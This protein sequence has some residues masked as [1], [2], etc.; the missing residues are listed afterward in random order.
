MQT[1]PPL[2]NAPF[3]GTPQASR[4][5]GVLCM[6]GGI[7]TTQK[8]PVCGGA[9]RDNGRWG[10]TC[11]AH[12]EQEAAKLI[13]KFG[14]VWKRFRSYEAA[15]RFL[16]GLR[17]KVDEGSF[18]SRDYRK[19]NP[20]GFSTLA[21][22][23]L[24]KKKADIRPRVWR[25]Y[26]NYMSKAVGF[27]GGRNIKEIGYAD[28]E[29]FL[30]AQRGLSPKTRA[31]VLS[32][33]HHFWVWLRKRRVITPAQFPEFPEVK[34]ELGYRRT[35]DKETQL[36]ILEEVRRLSWDI[37]PRV[38]IGIRFLCTYISIRPA[39]MAALKEG[40]ID[41]GNG[42]LLIP[43]PKEKTLKRVPLTP[44]DIELLRALPRG[45]PELPFF[46]HIR[47]YKGSRPGQPFG[48]KHFYNWWKRACRNLGVEGVDLYGGTRHSSALAL[49]AEGYSPE[50]I[51]RAT[52]HATNKA[53]E[54]Y[55]RIEA[56]EIREVYGAAQTVPRNPATGSPAPAT[57]LHGGAT[58]MQ[59][60]FG[61]VKNANLLI[62]KDKD[63]R[64]GRI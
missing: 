7:Y 23:W 18:D 9:M 35:V 12:P 19:D 15:Q 64:G 26:S 53:F 5:N 1:T 56:D 36:A 30:E 39:E 48:I 50:Q 20:L 2:R 24:E 37:N 32:A 55:Y 52:M 47:G 63:G 17:F 31:N 49:R 45:L 60:D 29:D 8:C 33:L 42:Y 4:A 61:G 43:H 16:T 40:D 10:V 46:R 62:F 3:S 14:K 27:F 22:Q 28:L 6:L 38:Y 11:P 34:Y 54:R 58:K 25:N 57:R 44:E 59:P 41:L 13:V 51:R 21:G